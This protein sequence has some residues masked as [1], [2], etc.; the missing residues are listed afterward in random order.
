MTPAGTSNELDVQNEWE[1]NTR[2]TVVGV[3]KEARKAH[4]KLV[5]GETS[6]GTTGSRRCHWNYP[7]D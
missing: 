4:K 1:G 2:T 6:K 3:G 7:E 5:H